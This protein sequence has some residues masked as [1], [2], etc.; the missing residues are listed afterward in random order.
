[1]TFKVQFT[2]LNGAESCHAGGVHAFPP[3]AASAA[4]AIFPAWL[5][6]SMNVISNTFVQTQSAASMKTDIRKNVLE[7]GFLG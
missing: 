4:N 7:I 5:T 1:M 6:L 3:S 2:K